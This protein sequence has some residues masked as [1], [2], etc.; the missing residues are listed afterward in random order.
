MRRLMMVMLLAFACLASAEWLQ[1]Q[2]LRAC[3]AGNHGTRK[4]DSAQRQ[5]SP[6]ARVQNL[7]LAQL[8]RE[9]DELSC[10]AQSIPTDVDAV[11]KGMLPRDVLDKLKRIEKIS[12]R[13]RGALAP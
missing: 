12:K 9:A 8:Q 7:D 3:P 10:L 5:E 2:R 4:Y 1:A 6:Q 13:L 11:G